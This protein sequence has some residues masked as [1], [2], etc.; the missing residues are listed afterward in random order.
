MNTRTALYWEFASSDVSR[1]G[2]FPPS[3]LELSYSQLPPHS[4]FRSHDYRKIWR[5]I[6]AGYRAQ[7]TDCPALRFTG[8]YGWSVSSPGNC[9]IRRSTHY[10]KRRI[11]KEGF[12]AYG[13]IEI[14]G[15]SWPHGDSGLVASWIMNSGFVKIHTGINILFPQTVCVYQGPLPN[16]DCS[17]FDRFEIWQGI[18]CFDHSRSIHY[19]GSIL[20]KA[21]LNFVGR[22]R[23]GVKEVFVKRGEAIGWFFPVTSLTSLNLVPVAE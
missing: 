6:E 20:G 12:A 4:P 13:D 5:S 21:E 11:V 8:R 9:T 17:P 16:V 2:A 15:D 10:R 1:S 18:E 22:L 3:R 14:E 23:S 19:D 7:P